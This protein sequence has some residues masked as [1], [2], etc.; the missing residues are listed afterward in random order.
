MD[1]IIKMIYTFEFAEDTVGIMIKSKVDSRLIDEVHNA[2]IDK[3]KVNET[4]NLF[5]EI[6]P[7]N[8][9]TISALL[10][11]LKFKSEHSSQFKK[12]AV[13]TD[14]KWFHSLM[15]IKDLVM[16]AEVKTFDHKNRLKAINWIAE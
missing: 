6:E 1:L 13:V 12:I 4:I 9:I 7:G 14:L 2:I 15:E 8:N 11:D 10:K 3:L 16:D 5:I